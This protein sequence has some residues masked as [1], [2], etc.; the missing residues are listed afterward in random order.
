MKQYFKQFSV[1][2]AFCLLFVFSSGSVVAESV[3]Y[4]TP[5]HV[6][7]INDI[8]GDGSGTYY[9][10]DCLDM[11]TF[12][13]NDKDKDVTRLRLLSFRKDIDTSGQ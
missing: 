5:Y 1:L 3:V 4:S 13:Y 12:V 9:G 6:F 7:S 2:A 10:T 8:Q 11:E